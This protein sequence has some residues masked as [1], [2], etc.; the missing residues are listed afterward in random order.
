MKKKKFFQNLGN[1]TI[2]GIFITFVTFG[3]YSV[4]TYLF[5]ENFEIT[6]TNYYALEQGID[7][8]PNPAPFSMNTMR[9]CVVCSLLCSTDVVAAVSIVDY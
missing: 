4:L 3:I 7:V 9:L 5:V 8:G 2:F 1:I 6:M